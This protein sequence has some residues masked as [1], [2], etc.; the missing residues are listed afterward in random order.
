MK[1]VKVVFMDGKELLATDYTLSFS[2]GQYMLYSNSDHSRRTGNT[3]E[4]YV[5]FDNVRCVSEEVITS[6]IPGIIL[7]EKP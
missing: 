7:K 3:P 6:G 4:R 1:L 2:Q 5:P